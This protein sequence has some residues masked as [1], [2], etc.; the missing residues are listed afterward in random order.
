M[1]Q[2]LV[3]HFSSLSHSQETLSYRLIQLLAITVC[4][5]LQKWWLCWRRRECD[6]GHVFHG[7]AASIRTPWPLRNT[8]KS[9]C[10]LSKDSLRQVSVQLQHLV[11][12]TVHVVSEHVFLSMFH[13][14]IIPNWIFFSNFQRKPSRNDLPATTYHD[15]Q[16]R[17]GESTDKS[18]LSV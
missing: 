10:N 11:R 15:W 2:Q 7:R 4:F 5:Y 12:I 8:H 13:C 17:K 3:N 16:R 1:C 18:W 14:I 6:V 9:A